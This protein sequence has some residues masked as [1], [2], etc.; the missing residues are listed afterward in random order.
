[1]SKKAENMKVLFNP[2]SAAVVGAS[3]KQDKLGF[4]VMKSLISGG[5][6]GRIIPVP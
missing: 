5:F 4:H 2:A 1:M 6:S 3:D